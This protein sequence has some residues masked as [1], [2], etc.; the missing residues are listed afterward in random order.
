M[1]YYRVA[2]SQFIST[3]VGCNKC[4]KFRHTKVNC[5]KDE[6]CNKSWQ[7]DHTRSEKCKHEAKCV[8][9]QGNHAS[10]DKTSPI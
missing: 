2:V 10:N 6:V 3:R 4:Q 8:N 7:E 1:G 5:R 9:C